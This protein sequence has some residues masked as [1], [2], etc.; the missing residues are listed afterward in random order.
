MSSASTN[1]PSSSDLGQVAQHP[2]VT[3]TPEQSESS[4]I[5]LRDATG[6]SRGLLVHD[7]GVTVFFSPERLA[8]LQRR[9]ANPGPVKPFREALDN[10]MRRAR[11]FHEWRGSKS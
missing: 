10:A 9:A 11:E 2:I 4:A 7:G 5:E 8:E 1:L 3:L 6:N